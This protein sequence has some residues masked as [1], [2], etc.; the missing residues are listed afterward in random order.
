MTAPPRTG[1]VPHVVRRGA[2][3]PLLLVHGNGV[4]HRLLLELDHVLADGWERIYVDLPGFGRTP[5]LPGRGGLADLLEW[6]DGWV[7]EVVGRTPFAVVGNS[8]GGLLAAHLAAGRGD[9]CLGA[10]LLA[11]VIETRHDLRTLPAREVSTDPALLASLDPADADEYAAVAVDQGP[12]SWE[13][14]RR[15]VL[16]GLRAGDPQAI[17]RLGVAYELPVP[18]ATGLLGATL[19]VTGRQDTIVGFADQWTWAEGLPRVT[20]A[21]LDRAGH[22]VHLDQPETVAALL[23]AWATRVRAG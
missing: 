15:A 8:M 2:G 23:T 12:Q 7:E 19:V 3:V 1:P 9:Q 20:F 21:A 6:L 16:P 4:D 5:G 13:R 17:R 10:A 22:N 18:A 14:F 11:P